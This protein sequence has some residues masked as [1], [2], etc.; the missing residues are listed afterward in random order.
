MR[1][2]TRPSH[3]WARPQSPQFHRGTAVKRPSLTAQRFS[4]Y[5]CRSI[6]IHCWWLGDC[7][8]SVRRLA[9]ALS[10]KPPKRGF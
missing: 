9:C 8:L 6:D 1:D 2:A 5:Q 4:L 10:Q 3:L 7:A